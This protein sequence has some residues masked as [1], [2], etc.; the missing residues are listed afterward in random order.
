MADELK[1][2]QKAESAADI[3]SRRHLDGVYKQRGDNDFVIVRVLGPGSSWNSKK[4]NILGRLAAQYGNGRLHVT[5]RGDFELSSV[6]HTA[7][8]KLLSELAA[9]G[10]STRGACGDCIR[11]I[12]ACPGAG[13]CENE[14]IDAAAMARELHEMLGGHSA[15]EHLP[16]KFK[17]SVSGCPQ[18]C[19]LPWLQDVGL[20]A[21]KT[22]A[23]GKQAVGF[24]LYLAGG[25]G[26]HPRMAQKAPE[27]ISI[28]S[29]PMLVRTI[30]ECFN[31]LGDRT[32][33][34]RARFKFVAERIGQPALWDEIKKRIAEN[35]W[36]YVI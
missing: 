10:L 1:P 25:L 2:L 15:Y 18:G 9:A 19:A 30:V 13:I 26:R 36:D 6:P 31:E 20:T 12:S 23:A 32:K 24:H 27:I 11:N 28:S 17:I 22:S 5:T 16:R 8:E 33:R 4:L 3:A 34:H 7:I 14:L 21:T 35:T 29:A